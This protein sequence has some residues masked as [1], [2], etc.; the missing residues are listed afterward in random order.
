MSA[1]ASLA[2]QPAPPVP[3]PVV[4]PPAVEL[5]PAASAAAVAASSTM[6]ATPVQAVA[7]HQDAETHRQQDAR[8]R[9]DSNLDG[10]FDEA[11]HTRS[12]PRQGHQEVPRA[13]AK[14]R[15][16]ARGRQGRL[17]TF[18]KRLMPTVDSG[19][20]CGGAMATMPTFAMRA[21]AAALLVG[22]IGDG[23]AQASAREG[24]TRPRATGGQSDASPKRS[25]IKPL[26]RKR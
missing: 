14:T 20:E 21:A 2:T 1:Q 10:G 22:P 16:Q 15:A 5:A 4:T 13:A 6:S 11:V 8:L 3:L 19:P 23:G 12:H 26:R 25:W 9:E 7:E 18:S 24:G 17:S